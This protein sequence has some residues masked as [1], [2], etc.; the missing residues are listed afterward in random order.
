MVSYSARHPAERGEA[1]VAKKQGACLS[2]GQQMLFGRLGVLIGLTTVISNGA[3]LES[4]QGQGPT[5]TQIETRK[6]KRSAGK[7]MD[8]RRSSRSIVRVVVE[9]W[10]DK[11][12]KKGRDSEKRRV[13]FCLY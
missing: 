12:P 2:V 11:N 13:F 3:K 1:K 6:R 7:G 10:G 9:S 4:A 8:V 5:E